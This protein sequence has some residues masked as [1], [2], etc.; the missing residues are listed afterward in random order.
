MSVSAKRIAVDRRLL[1]LVAAMVRVV[2]REFL[3]R[4][5]VTL[6]PVQPRR[7][8][9]REVRPH[10]GTPPLES[11]TIR[12]RRAFGN[13][14]PDHRPQVV[15]DRWFGHGGVLPDT[16]SKRSM[17]V[18]SEMPSMFQGVS[19]GAPNLAPPAI[20]LP[21][22]QHLPCQQKKSRWP[23]EPPRPCWLS[24]L[25]SARGLG[26]PCPLQ[27]RKQATNVIHREVTHYKVKYTPPSPH[28]EPNT[29]CRQ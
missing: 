12:A 25:Y 14:R 4:A 26:G 11:R 10:I 2:Q 9:R 13:E 7:V 3:Q 16:S 29:C 8:A 5:E 24:S 19:L 21:P 6:D 27:G 17:A 23:F 22:R 28:C 20:G 18:S 1:L 15:R